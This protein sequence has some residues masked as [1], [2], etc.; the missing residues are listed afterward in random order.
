[1]RT[2]R[3]PSDVKPCFLDLDYQPPVT[4]AAD[5]PLNTVFKVSSPSPYNSDERCDLI[6]VGA[7]FQF[8]PTDRWAWN[9]LMLEGELPEADNLLGAVWARTT[10]SLPEEAF[11]E[12]MPKATAFAKG[13]CAPDYTYKGSY[14]ADIDGGPDVA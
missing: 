14:G 5:N 4:N 11:E 1:M 2:K 7:F 8:T 3:I 12:H 13:K 10:N 9:R 6:F